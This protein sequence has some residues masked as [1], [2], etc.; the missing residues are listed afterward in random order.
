MEAEQPF[1]EIEVMKMIMP[2]TVTHAGYV[3]LR[4]QAG[5]VMAAGDVVATLQLDDPTKVWGFAFRCSGMA[6]CL[7]GLFLI[8]LLLPLRPTWS[9]S[10]Q[11]GTLAL[12]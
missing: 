12:V 1:A 11:Y 7:L 6:V 3:H 9:H 2:L 5:A 8:S 4:L 10:L